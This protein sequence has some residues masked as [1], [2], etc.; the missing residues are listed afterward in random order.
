MNKFIGKIVKFLSPLVYIYVNSSACAPPP[1]DSNGWYK[2]FGY[3]SGGNRNCH[4][5]YTIDGMVYSTRFYRPPYGR[6]DVEF[7]LLKYNP[8]DPSQVEIIYS[9]P[10]FLKQE[11]TSTTTG[12]IDKIFKIFVGSIKAV[13]YSYI[14]DGIKYQ[15]EQELPLD[16]EIQYPNLKVGRTYNVRYLTSNPKRAI[17]ILGSE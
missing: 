7:Y 13:R 2:A 1:V 3:T 17:I 10:I 8:T 6:T 5:N 9:C 14:V 15:R 11:I 4:I 16:F 12:N